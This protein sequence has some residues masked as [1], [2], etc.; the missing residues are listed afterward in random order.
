MTSLSRSAL[1][2]CGAAAWLPASVTSPNPSSSPPPPRASLQALN[3][4]SVSDLVLGPVQAS[5]QPPQGPGLHVAYRGPDAVVYANDR[6]LPRVFLVDRQRT[7]GGDAAALDAVTAQGF[8]GRSVAVT[9]RPLPGVAEVGAAAGSG[10]VGV[11]SAGPSGSVGVCRGLRGRVGAGR[12]RRGLRSRK[13]RV[14]SY[15]AERVVVD[16]TAVRPSLLVL[17]DN[18]YP[19]WSVSVD[20]HSARLHRVD[21]LLRGVVL[22]PGH[23]TVVFS[24]SPASFRIGWIVS[25]VCLLLVV[26]ALIVGV[27]ERRRR[28]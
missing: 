7:V 22:P 5:R 11:G 12:G 23:H 3:L 26:G 13:R 2:R 8:D 6:A 21:Y 15:G 14:R 4:L 27:R 19:G 17:T 24:Y 20:G 1:T 16:A 9:E 28:A 25:L 10:G 18:S